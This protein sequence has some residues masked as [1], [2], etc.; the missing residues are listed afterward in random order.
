MSAFEVR[1]GS[2]YGQETIE[3]VDNESKLEAVILPGFGS[4]LI[5]LKNT[6]KDIAFIKTP[7]D[8]QELKNRPTG[9]GTPVL[10]PPGR[11]KGGSFTFQGREYQFEKNEKGG[12]NHIHGLVL[13]RPW[14]VTKTST[15]GAAI[16]QTRF[17]SRSFPELSQY[18]PQ[19]FTISLTF[20]LSGDTLKVETRAE[21]HAQEPMPLWLGF[22]PYFQVPL[23]PEST[24]ADCF[25]SLDTAH[26]WELAGLVPTGQR[27]PVE[28]KYDLTRGQ[29]LEGLLLDDVYTAKQT[30]NLSSARFEDKKAKAG[31]EY[32]AGPSFKHWVIYTGKD[33]EADFVCLE[34]YTGV[35]NAPNLTLPMEETGLIALEK[36]KPFVEK[37]E[38]KI[39]C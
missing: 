36:G 31:I 27:F 3:L 15:D 23:G 17:S 6:A 18:L 5:S 22:H 24:K 8:F 39:F 38:L 13:N 34:P 29:C 20:T 9:F 10:M 16:V 4:N 37:M 12:Q 28:G 33:L 26:R 2:F 14:E 21:N 19:P 7:G 35:P 32:T 30:N 11:I 1:T 25:I